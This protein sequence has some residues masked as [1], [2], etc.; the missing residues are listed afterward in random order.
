[1]ANPYQNKGPNQFWRTAIAELSADQVAP[2]PFKRFN[3][4]AG[5]KVA[6]AGSCFAQHVA[7][8]LRTFAGV[9]F[10]ESEPIADGQPLFSAAY[11]NIYTVRQLLQ[12]FEEAFGLTSVPSESW[13]RNDGKWIDG[14][15]PSVFSAGFC[16]SN[17]VMEARTKHLAA[18]R[19]TFTSCSVFIFTLGLTEA[20]LSDPDSR[21]F[22]I[23][24]GVLSDI[25]TAT[26]VRFHN[27]T[28]DEVFKD[29]ARF[30]H[31]FKSINANAHIILTVSPVPLVATYTNEH[32][33]V[34][35]THSKSVLRAVCGEAARIWEHAYYF[36]SYE[37]I[38]SHINQ[39]HYYATNKRS[40]TQDG[41]DH[42]MAVFRRSYLS[43][44]RNCHESENL[45]RSGEPFVF[46]ERPVMCDE[47]EYG[48]NIGF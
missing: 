22:P 39:G 47:E 29:L 43:S 36:P 45:Y 1:M 30:Y 5:S 15:R 38:S 31:A 44:I 32:V 21:V 16:S 11:G 13:L 7:K 18:V 27:F 25:P 24:P 19:H 35:N 33:L 28:Y 2:V 23:P 8:T 9:D 46:T 17:D 10:I 48:T 4:T 12:L 26:I 41:V 14:Y 37:I 40:V 20:W 6:T 42:V 3:I 34:A